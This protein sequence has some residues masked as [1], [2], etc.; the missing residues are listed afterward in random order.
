MIHSPRV[1]SDSTPTSTSLLLRNGLCSNTRSVFHVNCAML[2]VQ[3]VAGGR[4]HQPDTICAKLVRA[5][6]ELC[7]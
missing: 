4:H 7:D 1:G 6:G 3:P 2:A 5:I